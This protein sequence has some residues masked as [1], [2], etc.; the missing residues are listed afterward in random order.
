MVLA[1]A[2]A[3]CGDPGR[4]QTGHG[5]L[6]AGEIASADPFDENVVATY[7]LTIDPADWD[8]IVAN[9]KDNTWRKCTVTWQ[10]E[11]YY[12][13]AVRGAGHVSAIP[14]S[15]KP[16]VRLKFNYY[17]PH[18]KFHSIYVSG[19]KLLGDNE[20]PSMM[21]QRIECGVYRSVG[22]PAPRCVHS[23]VFVNGQLKGL[24]EVEERVKRGFIKMHFGRAGMNQLYDWPTSHPPDVQWIGPDPITYYVPTMWDPKMRKL[25]PLNPTVK[26]PFP[27]VAREF[28]RIVNLDTWPDMAAA[29]ETEMFYRFMAAEVATGEG[30][31]YVAFNNGLDPSGG[32]RSA[33]FR[34]YKNQNTGKYIIIPWDKDQGYWT[35]RDSITLGFDQRIMTSKII[36]ANPDA[37][38]RYR[39][40]LGDLVR[41]PASVEKMNARIDFVANQVMPFAFQDTMKSAGTDL[42]WLAHIQTIRNYIA[43]HN[44]MILS[45][46][47]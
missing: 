32:Y 31:S 9:P 16:S 42:N 30:D 7:E 8:A 19:V 41:G 25:D 4:G 14:G 43:T 11:V 47:P 36:L 38:A 28:V 33:N 40:I 35:P 21:R 26:V 23:M 44:A 27:E 24:Y 10:G 2:L 29:V 37:L 18:R 20:D 15:R 3:G 45:Q 17:I 46:T 5:L 12:D 6:A 22:L 1:A 34:L 13:V 39:Q